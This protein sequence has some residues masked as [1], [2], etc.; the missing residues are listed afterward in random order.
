MTIDPCS[1][2]IS[3]IRGDTDSL[4]LRCP[5]SPFSA[6]T[7]LRL[8]VRRSPTGPIL[9]QKT[10][11]AFGE[12]G[13][14]SLLMTTTNLSFVHTGGVAGKTYAYKVVAVAENAEA[15]SA[16]SNVVSRTVG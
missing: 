13:E 2:D 16:F 11:D 6:G 12:D 15:N 4:T 8:T 1:R 9:L 5:A 7:V 10:V 3:L 14:F